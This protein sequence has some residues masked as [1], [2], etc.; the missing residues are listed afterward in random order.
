MATHKALG[1]G[2]NALF[3]QAQ[4]A[5]PLGGDKTLDAN[6]GAQDQV[7]DISV[8]QIRPNRHQ[9]RSKF[10]PEALEELAQ[11]IKLHGVA[12]PLVVSEAVQEGEFELVMGERRLRA[13]K[14]AGLATV[15]CFVKKV[16]NQERFELALI[17]NLQ[18]EDLNPLEEAL[19]VDT[20]MKNTG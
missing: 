9:P 19:A 16:S 7:R 11:S 5:R 17:E 1:R 18:R 2:L 15:P 8:M 3:S 12:Q 20:L 4:A 10:E 13:D 14:M 6:P